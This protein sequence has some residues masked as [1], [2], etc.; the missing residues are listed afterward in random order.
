MC[1][2]WQEALQTGDERAV[3]LPYTRVRHLSHDNFELE[4]DKNWLFY[5][6]EKE[7]FDQDKLNTTEV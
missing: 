4:V 1:P 2:H 6:A 3:V 7:N 5:D